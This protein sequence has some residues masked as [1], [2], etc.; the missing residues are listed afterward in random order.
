MRAMATL[1]VQQTES[2]KR[3]K[4]LEHQ[5]ESITSEKDD[6]HGQLQAANAQVFIAMIIFTIPLC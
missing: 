2:E 3:V 5:L 6:L 4:E 1:S